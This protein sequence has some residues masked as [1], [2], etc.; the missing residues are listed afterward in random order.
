MRFSIITRYLLAE[1]VFTLLAVLAVLL[2]ILVGG[3]FAK[4]LGNVVA[5]KISATVLFPLLAVGSLNSLGTLI[6]VALFL[7]VLI[8]LGRMYKDNEMTALQASGAG[9]RPVIKPLLVI[10]LLTAILLIW[11]AFWVQPWSRVVTENLR[12]QSSQVLDIGGITPGRFIS[13][14]GTNQVVFAESMN[15]AE[16]KLETVFLFRQFKGSAQVISADSATQIKPD[17]SGKRQLVLDQGEVFEI[18]P[19]KNGYS[20]GTFDRQ[21]IRLPDSSETNGKTSV[22]SLAT[23]K[24]MRSDGIEEKA[25]LHWRLS[26][27]VSVVVLVLLAIP[28]SYTTPRKGQFAKLVIAVLIYVGYVNFLGLGRS[29]MENSQIPASLGLWWVH[30]LIFLLA[31][32]LYANQQGWHWFGSHNNV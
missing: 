10:G 30:G 31:F 14:P 3:V 26:Y 20:I 23:S 24:L 9:V 8:T 25:E 19:Q 13:I 32:V 29:W 7:S 4:L 1:I 21:K 18:L 16:K 12:S 11:L 17:G 15:N 6:V 22:R 27:P 2:L 28:L 5:G